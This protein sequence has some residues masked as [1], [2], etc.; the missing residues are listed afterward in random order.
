MLYILASIPTF[1]VGFGLMNYVERK[2][3]TAERESVIVGA[4]ASVI[5]TGIILC[6]YGI[7]HM[8]AKGG[9]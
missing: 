8:T 7:V 2:S 3:L 1:G 5:L 9:W 6:I 4:G